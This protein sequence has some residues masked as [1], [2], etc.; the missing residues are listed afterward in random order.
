MNKNGKFQLATFS[1]VV[2]GSNHNL[3]NPDFLRVNKIVPI[4]QEV[5]KTITTP[6]VAIVEYKS[7]LS[8]TVEMEKLQVLQAT[9][10]KPESPISIVPDVAMAYIR[11]LPHVP[12][13]AVGINWIGHVIV[14]NPE[15]W[16]RDRFIIDGPWKGKELALAGA[17]VR[18]IYS[19]NEVRCNLSLEPGQAKGKADSEP[20]PVLIVN[21]NYHHDITK[22]LDIEGICSIIATWKEREKHF[23]KLITTVLDVEV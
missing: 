8:I 17:G 3:L 5:T 19:V 7:G 20:Q 21:G 14:K 2:V 11:T 22:N 18:L 4:D 12:Y 6:P 16:V 10:E 23:K 9:L 1:V 15:T 13:K